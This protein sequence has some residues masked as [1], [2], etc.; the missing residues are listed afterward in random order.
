MAGNSMRS[1]VLPA[2]DAGAWGAL[3][4]SPLVWAHEAADAPEAHD[5]YV[6]LASIAELPGWVASLA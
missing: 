6:E 4:P 5:R 2:L 3:I 1:D